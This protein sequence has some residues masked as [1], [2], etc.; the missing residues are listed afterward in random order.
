M[1]FRVIPHYCAVDQNQEDIYIF[2]FREYKYTKYILFSKHFALLQAYKQQLHNAIPQH[3]TEVHTHT[4][5]H[6]AATWHT[7]Q[8]I[9]MLAAVAFIY[10]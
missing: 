9:T 6:G 2:F 10:S 3:V 4:L 5:N 1:A 8:N 7:P